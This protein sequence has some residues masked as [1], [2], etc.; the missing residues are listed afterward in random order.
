MQRQNLNPILRSFSGILLDL[1]GTFMFGQDRFGPQ[2]DY[3]ATYCSMGGNVLAGDE[4]RAGI[5]SCFAELD[6]ISN[7]SARY[8]SF[9]SVAD[10][11]RTL[12]ETSHLPNRERL[13]VESVYAYHEVGHVPSSYAVV[14]QELALT[15]RLGLVSNIWSKKEIFVLELERAEVL[16]LF[17]ALVFSSEGICIKPSRA[18][19][20]QAVAGLTLPLQDVVMIGDNL[21]CDVGGA[22][23]AGLASIW[24]NSTGQTIPTSAPEPDYIISD[25]Q[26]LLVHSH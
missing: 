5:D 17:S 16:K 13:L 18:I 14:L 25:L 15:H 11:L 22:A 4:L 1:N 12:P 10:V 20:D 23:A 19:F 8:D 21:Q 3:Y 2:Y 6:R 26:E 9:P 24:I 7:N